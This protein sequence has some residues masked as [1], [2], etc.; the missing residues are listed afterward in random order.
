MSDQPYPPQWHRWQPEDLLQAALPV[1]DLRQ[2]SDPAADEEAVR[3]E[4]ARMRKQAEQQGRSQGEEEGQRQGYDAGHQAGY[5]AG[6]EQGLAE[7]QAR[8]QGVLQEAV[9]WIGGF[10]EALENLDSLIPARLVQLAL[11]AVKQLYGGVQAND[12]S[13]LLAQIKRLM[14]QDAMLQGELCL[15]IHPQDWALIEPVLGAELNAAGWRITQDPQLSPGGCRFSQQEA[16]LD[17]TLE[18]RWQTLC[19]WAQREMSP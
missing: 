10:R 8:Q 13:A 16:E 7:A 3:A 18:T 9:V 5:Q 4:L 6:Y 19:Q 11:Q 1:Q 15:Q 12:G 14:Q 17:A 2:E